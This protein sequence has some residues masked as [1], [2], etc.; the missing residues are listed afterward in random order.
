MALCVSV[1]PSFT[2]GATTTYIVKVMGKQTT[3]AP[4]VQGDNTYVPL[5]EIAQ[6]MGES[7]TSNSLQKKVI[8]KKKD[9][10]I[11]SV[12]SNQANAVWKGK[13]AP[14]KTKQINKV[15]VPVN[16]KAVYKNG[17]VYVPVEFLSASNGMAYSVK[18]ANEGGKKV[19]HVGKPS[20][21]PK[22]T[23]PPKK[24]TPPTQPSTGGGGKVYPDGWVAPVLKSSWS[25]DQAKNYQILQNELGF[26]DGGRAYNI[27]GAPDAISV[28]S[29]G[30]TGS[31]EVSINFSMWGNDEGGRLKQ[32]YRVP[33]V[34][35][36]VFKL[37]FGN[38]APRVWDYFNSGK[39]IPDR[40]TANGRTVTTT[41]SQATGVL[42]LK[43][44]KK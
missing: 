39:D 38:D 6:K 12:T 28:V 11:I 17:Q 20:A 29:Q 22:Q 13:L 10:T 33:V 26:T 19:I 3:N 23:E 2:Q 15:T 9:G 41:Y 18:I 14:L 32:A 35:K 36:E 24:P 4:F 8:I 21:P 1:F 34:A 40:F 42:S 44:G 16:A 37:Y 25:P 7:V 43:V 27:N 5:N 30:N 31:Y